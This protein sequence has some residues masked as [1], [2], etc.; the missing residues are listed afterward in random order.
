[1]D[2]GNT[3][4]MEKNN[5]FLTREIVPAVENI[6][7][8]SFNMRR[9]VPTSIKLQRLYDLHYSKLSACFHKTRTLRA[10]WWC[11]SVFAIYKWMGH[12]RTNTTNFWCD[13]PLG[14]FTLSCGHKAAR[15]HSSPKN[16]FCF[17]VDFA[18]GTQAV[19]M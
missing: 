11:F 17:F 13:F 16:D 18:Y 4:Q 5:R 2:E 10:V 7:C 12:G 15:C 1:M 6:T 14:V 3:Q 19:L 9:K 8:F